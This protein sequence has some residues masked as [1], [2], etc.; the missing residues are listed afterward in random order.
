MY[1][2]TYSVQRVLDICM[3]ISDVKKCFL[4]YAGM[5]YVCVVLKERWSIKEKKK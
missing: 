2:V 4:L 5:W 1:K 3:P